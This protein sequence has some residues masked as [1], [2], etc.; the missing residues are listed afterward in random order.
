MYINLFTYMHLLDIFANLLK[1]IYKIIILYVITRKSI[2]SIMIFYMEQ[3]MKMKS[4]REGIFIILS[5]VTILV[6][7]ILLL[8]AGNYLAENTDKISQD[9]IEKLS[10]AEPGVF[11]PV[12][13][14]YQ[15]APKDQDV[16]LLQQLSAR[17]N[18][19]LDIINALA[20]EI[21]VDKVYELAQSTRIK[22]L[23]PDRTVSVCLDAASS[24]A[25]STDV[26]SYYNLT[27]FGVT[28]AILDSGIVASDDLTTSAG[29]NRIVA[30][31]DFVND[32]PKKGYD[33]YGH[34]TYI[35]GIIGMKAQRDSSRNISR[36]GIAPDSALVSVRVL[37]SNGNG[38]ASSVIEGIEWCLDHAAMYN[39]RIINLS[40]S[41]PIFESYATDPLTQAC[42]KAWSAGLVVVAAAGNHGEERSGYATIG[43]PGNDPYIITVGSTDDSG[44]A[45][46]DDD[47]VAAFSSRGPALIDY[48]LKPDIVAPGTSLLSLRTPNSYLDTAYPS[49]RVSIDAATYPYFRL[50]GT[51]ISAAIVSGTAALLIQKEPSLTPSSVKARLMRSADKIFG[52]DIYTRGAGY[53]NIISALHEPGIAATSASPHVRQTSNG[54]FIDSILWDPDNYFKES[55]IWGNEIDWGQ[56]NIDGDYSVWGSNALPD[57]QSSWSSG[58]SEESVMVQ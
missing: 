4:K 1:C 21:P 58:S 22:S 38:K 17:I 47:T 19:E 41:H 18:K 20:I 46:R 11:T 12:I 36:S 45:S 39:I 14:Q 32:K 23:S 57:Y 10:F 26:L 6:C 51:S 2:F 29:K 13:V 53:L 28:I 48:I 9:L 16:A 55:P 44:T 49:N 3:I 27:G 56:D 30:S 15:D 50:N 35:A 40:F 42:E 33:Y 31:V 52:A 5:S 37:G 34:G 43:S 8:T 25:G 54:I 7:A 24:A